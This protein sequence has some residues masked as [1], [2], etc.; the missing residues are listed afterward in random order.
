MAGDTLAFTNQLG[1]TGSYSTASGVGVLTLTGTAPPS[2]Y[3]VALRAVTFSTSSGAA[4]G[5]R[6]ISFTANDGAGNGNTA[7]KDIIVSASGGGSPVGFASAAFASSG[8]AESSGFTAPGSATS[9]A[10]ATVGKR[11][12]PQSSI[13]VRSSS[14]TLKAIHTDWALATTANHHTRHAQSAATLSD[15]LDQLFAKWH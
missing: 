11:H 7:T 6:T 8:D 5:T 12:A 14:K 15:V 9:D 4:A 1:I 3:Q 10:A 2:D 13:T